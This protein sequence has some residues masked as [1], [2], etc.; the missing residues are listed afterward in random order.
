MNGKV[1]KIVDDLFHILMHTNFH[2][3]K[4]ELMWK[5]VGREKGTSTW[6]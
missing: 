3:L 4:K 1:N 5:K 6:G 2:S